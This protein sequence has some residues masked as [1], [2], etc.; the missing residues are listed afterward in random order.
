MDNISG[1]WLNQYLNNLNFQR[2]HAPGHRVPVGGVPGQEPACEVGGLMALFHHHH[3]SPLV[4]ATRVTLDVLFG[5][6][7]DRQEPLLHVSSDLMW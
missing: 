4:A 3:G 2:L 5:C 1:F 6:K 7:R